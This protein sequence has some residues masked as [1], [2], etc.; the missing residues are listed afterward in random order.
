M[1]QKSFND[2]AGMATYLLTISC[3][4]GGHLENDEG[5]FRVSSLMSFLFSV[6]LVFLLRYS[7]KTS[8]FQHPRLVQI[9]DRQIQ[10][11]FYFLDKTAVLQIEVVIF[12]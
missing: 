11:V 10:V 2:I 12:V 5:L 8:F 1:L 9:C 4:Y 7:Y 6:V 3:E